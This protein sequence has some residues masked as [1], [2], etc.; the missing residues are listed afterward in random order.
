MLLSHWKAEGSLDWQVGES[1]GCERLSGFTSASYFQKRR[2]HHKHIKQKCSLNDLRTVSTYKPFPLMEDLWIFDVT[3][4]CSLQNQT[5][6]RISIILFHTFIAAWSLCVHSL[7]SE[8]FRWVHELFM[9]W[10]FFWLC[11]L[12]FSHWSVSQFGSK[13][14]VA[15]TKVG[16]ALD[17]R[18][19]I[20]IGHSQSSFHI[21]IIILY[22]IF[23]FLT[24]AV[25]CLS[26]YFLLMSGVRTKHQG[27]FLISENLFDNKPH[28]VSNCYNRMANNQSVSSM[29]IHTRNYH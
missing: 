12:S 9:S 23:I 10:C 20:S 29:L 8:V 13:L 16:P 3:V 27:T 26:L 4:Q 18:V 6:R 1:Q 7:N 15:A 19:H 25:L 24:V 28:S 17:C 5:D 11:S 2:K 21:C 22:S 14:S